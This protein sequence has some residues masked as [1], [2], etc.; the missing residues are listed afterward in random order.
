MKMNEKNSLKCC[1]LPKSSTTAS[2]QSPL[3]HNVYKKGDILSMRVCTQRS[4]MKLQTNAP[5]STKDITFSK[6]VWC[7]IAS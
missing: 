2:L 5:M 1:F 6:K 4:L 7:V 3:I